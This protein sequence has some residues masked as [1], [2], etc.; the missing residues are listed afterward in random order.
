[1]SRTKRYIP[2]DYFIYGGVRVLYSEVDHKTR[3]VKGDKVLYQT[4]YGN[5]WAMQNT[6]TDY[7]ILSPDGK[8][9]HKPTKDFKKLRRQIERSRAKQAVAQDKDPEVVKKN[10]IWDWN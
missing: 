9:W 2:I 6:K 8:P 4:I 10:D 5:R 3:T 7:S 1:M